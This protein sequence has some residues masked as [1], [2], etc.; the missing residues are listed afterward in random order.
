MASYKIARQIAG[1]L[2]IFIVLLLWPFNVAAQEIF[3][4]KDLETRAHNGC[5]SISLQG[6]EGGKDLIQTRW[7][8]QDSDPGHYP[9]QYGS[10]EIVKTQ[11]G[12][13]VK[14]GGSS[15]RRS[16]GK[17]KRFG[18][19]IHVSV[20][21]KDRWERCRLTFVIIDA[22]KRDA[23]AISRFNVGS[24]D[25]TNMRG[26][27]K[28]ENIE[29]NELEVRNDTIF[30]IWSGGSGY[31]S[32]EIDA[33]GE[34][35]LGALSGP[36]IT[37]SQAAIKSAGHDL[38]LAFDL[39]YRGE[40]CQLAF[41]GEGILK[42]LADTQF[43]DATPA[44][45][46]PVAPKALFVAKA[47]V[48]RKTSVVAQKTPDLSAERETAR[49]LAQA[50]RLEKQKALAE[51]AKSRREQENAQTELKREK[52]RIEAQK[53][54][55][56]QTDL[57]RARAKEDALW[58]SVSV[59]DS[60]EVTD[61]YLTL[62]PEGRYASE[63][64]IHK[65]KLRARL[66]QQRERQL[67][68][69]VSAQP[70]I[71]SLQDYLT[72]YP[73]GQYAVKAGAKLNALRELD[74]V[75]D[76]DFGNYYALV[77]GIDNYQNLPDLKAAVRDARAVADVLKNDYGF[78]VTFLEDPTRG[79]ILDELD[80]LRE[81]LG[82]RDNLLIYYAGHG[83][84]DEDANR[85]YWLPA[86]AKKNRRSRWLSNATLTDTLRS[87]QAK[88]VMVVADSCF[89]GTLTRATS[90]GLKSGDYWR[91]MANKRARVAIT[92]G[93]LEPVEDVNQL[94]KHSPFA[95]AFLNALR[96][97]E[98]IIDG[99]SLFNKIRRPVMI[100]ANQTPEY[101]DVRSAGHD[102]GDFLF[103]RKR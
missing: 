45:A 51:L 81:S 62:Y 18:R 46:T 96:G 28:C 15:I 63:A 66:R 44:A 95:Q 50:R 82:Y 11:S 77:I 102:G 70:T 23:P 3:S 98:A 78:D 22:F 1:L 7:T 61:L 53:L 71:R 72:R 13:N 86:D 75:R 60:L 59:S 19:N 69:Y 9:I 30:A 12:L 89:S 42:Q 56:M 101:S 37:A 33:S 64:L 52:R 92:S 4:E 35:M 5:S 88:H 100:N 29:V 91:R 39:T 20:A 38:H 10:I 6:F 54:A 99:T 93:G 25:P 74:Q 27:G 16:T 24:V 47:P 97:N 80:E 79:D 58:A 21:F 90:I 43:V 2:R 26:T 55:Q 8:W 85:G 34:R 36:K 31:G 84:L 83:W 68:Q 65:Q 76:I 32:V 73:F 17:A 87:L 67:W 49:Q 103:V 41:V 40:S 48:V 57:K 14:I 94:S